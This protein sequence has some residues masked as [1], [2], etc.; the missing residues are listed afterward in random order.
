MPKEQDVLKQIKSKGYWEIVIR[1]LKKKNRFTKSDAKEIL[2]K[3]SVKKYGWI[4]PIVSKK[5]EDCFLG[6]NYVE[7]IY[8]SVHGSEV[9]RL[10]ESGQFIYYRSLIEDW[11]K[12]KWYTGID[13]TGEQKPL[14]KI[15]GINL[16]IIELTI[17]YELMLNFF[18]CEKFGDFLKLSAILHDSEGRT[19]ALDNLFSPLLENYT[20]RIPEITWEKKYSKTDFASNYPQYAMEMI[21]EIT[22]IFN[23]TRPERETTMNTYQQMFLDGKI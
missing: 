1:P 23:W 7:G 17:L 4:F 18:D 14:P 15:K 2:S 6:Q 16:T 19:L 21:M 8:D 12:Q 10:Y 11:Q 5:S 13:Y 9:W 20:C 22:S 3:L